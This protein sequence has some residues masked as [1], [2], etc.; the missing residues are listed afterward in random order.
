VLANRRMSL[1][2]MLLPLARRFTV[3]FRAP[4]C[5]SAIAER[6]WLLSDHPSEDAA[7]SVL[8]AVFATLYLGSPTLQA[9][10]RYS[11]ASSVTLGEWPRARGFLTLTL[12]AG[13]RCTGKCR[14]NKTLYIRGHLRKSRELK[15]GAHA[16]SAV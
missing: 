13:N 1:L 14:L 10:R 7:N 3:D 9:S 8:K 4:L 11:T 16:N 5:Q 12:T 15:N 6:H 2:W